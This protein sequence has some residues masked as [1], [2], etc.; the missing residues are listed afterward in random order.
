MSTDPVFDLTNVEAEPKV[1]PE[2]TAPVSETTARELFAQRLQARQARKPLTF[3]VEGRDG[4]QV[5]YSTRLP[6]EKRAAIDKRLR[7][8]RTGVLDGPA[9]NFAVC[10]SQCEAI[11]ID[12][13]EV[14]MDGRPLTFRDREL[15]DMLGAT[16]PVNAVRLLYGGPELDGDYVLGAH[17]AKILEGAGFSAYAEDASEDDDEVPS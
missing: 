17:A 11:I 10:A 2:R 1:A 7:D 15:W 3:D 16:D 4:I 5:R 8:K 14:T 6:N 9:F 13:T 12:G